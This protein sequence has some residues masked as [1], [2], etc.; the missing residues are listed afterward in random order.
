MS[1]DLIPTNLFND[2]DTSM[3]TILWTLHEGPV[4][5]KQL[6]AENHVQNSNYIT[7]EVASIITKFW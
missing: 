7:H 5:M 4:P 1:V 6:H 3:Q 2:N